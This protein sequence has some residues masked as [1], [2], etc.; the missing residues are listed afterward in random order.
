MSHTYKIILKP[1]DSFYFGGEESFS[2]APLDAVV[3]S[4]AKAKEYF[5]KRQ[6]YFAKSEIFPQQ[7]QLLGMIRKEILRANEKLLYFKNFVRVPSDLKPKAFDL[8]GKT[9]WSANGTLDLGNIIKLSP[10]YIAKEQNGKTLRYFH[11]PFNG[12]FFLEE[13]EGKGYIN[14]KETPKVYALK[15]KEGNDFNAKSY[16]SSN[17]VAT[18]D[19]I[20]SIYD[21]FKS[22]TRVHTQTLPYKEEDEE[23][24]FK[25]TRYTLDSNYFFLF[26]LTTKDEVFEDGFETTVTL[27]GEGSYF[28]M[29]VTKEAENQLDTDFLQNNDNRIT[30]ISDAY[31]ESPVS[32]EST[33]QTESIFDLC[34]FIFAKKTILRTIESKSNNIGFKKSQ[35][36]ILF[37]KGTVFYPKE[38]KEEAVKQ[39]LESYKNFRAIGYNHY[40]DLTKGEYH[41]N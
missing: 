17:F 7:T 4:E 5:K 30:L 26:Y 21:L 38:G 12:N 20:V 37:T 8:V 41:G 3:S 34:K 2:D 19:E 25:V 32:L 29:K 39:L 18:K 10:L 28:T 22:H 6:G 36:Y 9:K 11:E 15:N 13:K 40:I 14:G 23:K 33:E 35:K 27:G 24:L 16:P 31:I 1:I